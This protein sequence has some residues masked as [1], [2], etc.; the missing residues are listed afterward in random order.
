MEVT[1]KN[2]CAKVIQLVAAYIISDLGGNVFRGA[3][4]QKADMAEVFSF[5]SFVGTETSP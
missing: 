3:L 4:L 5:T 2:L 1:K